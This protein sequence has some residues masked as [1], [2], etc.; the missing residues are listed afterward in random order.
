MNVMIDEQRKRET[1]ML[2]IIAEKDRQI[3]LMR[4]RE[5]EGS[6]IRQSLRQLFEAERT[7]VNRE[8]QE[9][10]KTFQKQSDATA[11]RLSQLS[12]EVRAQL[13]Q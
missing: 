10:L 13:E 8:M 5:T 6:E 2:R 12:P 7:H 3:E 9:F 11:E 4:E 1:E